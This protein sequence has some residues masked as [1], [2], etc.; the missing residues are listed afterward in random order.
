MES[1]TVATAQ[2][3]M[4]LFE[5][6]DDHR[7]ELARFMQVAATKG[8]QIAVFPALSGVLAASPQLEGFRMRLLKRAAQGRRQ[9]SL[10]GRTRK[11]LAGGTADLLKASFRQPYDALLAADPE[12][13]A[14]AHAALFQELAQAYS[15][16]VVAGS[17]Y[18][19]AEDGSFRHSAL[20]FGPDGALL[21]RH[22]AV[23]L[24]PAEEAWVQP[25]EGWTAIETPV[26]RVGV[27]FGEEALYP[28][29]GR[30]L[31][32]QGTELLVVVCATSDD[33][34]AAEVRLAAIARA[35]ED[36]CFALTSFAVGPDYLATQEDGL[37]M[38]AGR[39]GIYAPA[40]LTPRYSGALVEMGASSTEGLL[41]VELNGP[42][43]EELRERRPLRLD[44]VIPAPADQPTLSDAALSS[45]EEGETGA[46]DVPE[47]GD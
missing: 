17:A 43:L 25:G 37:V 29:V 20:I 16:T 40:E 28:E 39:S 24:S 12:A 44:R 2:Q 6:P 14:G 1:V 9:T 11:A 19:P 23:L 26:G 34:V 41:T 4:R 22:D 3:Q 47:T 35:Q 21:G 15:M 7:R 27:L 32:G 46:E 13:V 8:A 45:S 5:S 31:M 36:R 38:L 10:L 30:D 33:I 18:L 42:A